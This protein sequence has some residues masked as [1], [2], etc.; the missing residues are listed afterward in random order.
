MKIRVK[1]MGIL[2]SKSPPGN[3]VEIAPGA[4]IDDVLAAL[5]IPGNH[6]MLVSVNGKH[7]KDRTARL[8]PDDDLMI[9]PPAGGG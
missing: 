6:V 2:R 7:Q 5:G 3:Q 4:T 1:L 9:L 8:S